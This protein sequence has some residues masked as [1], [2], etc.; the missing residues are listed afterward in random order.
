MSNIIEDDALAYGNDSTDSNV[1]SSSA[2]NSNVTSSNVWVDWI[3]ELQSLAQAGLTYGT[4]RFDLERYER[5]RQISAEM[6]ARIAD[7]PP[8]KVAGLFCNETG[9]QTP[10]LDTRA[11]IFRDGR[12]L[13]VREL[14]GRWSLPG[15]W[16][17]VNVSVGE[18]TAKEARE[19]SGLDVRPVRIIAVQDRNRH[20]T[21]RYAYG[22]CKVFMECEVLGGAFEANSETTESGW[23]APGALPAMAVEK[24]TAEQVALCF[25]AHE[26]GTAWTP[27]FD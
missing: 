11:A 13:L 25:R 22:V 5:I 7:M 2:S 19:E 24:S 12:I 14:D 1:T 27:V 18:N 6:M 8:E 15:G 10:K 9:Y 17:D 26:A 21:P 4:G 20:N 3:V 23:F 16:C